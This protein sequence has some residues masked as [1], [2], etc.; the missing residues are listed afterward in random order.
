[1]NPT[2]L[3]SV[4]VQKYSTATTAT[5]KITLRNFCLRYICINMNGKKLNTSGINKWIN[6][7]L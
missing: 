7:I 3:L 5:I 4:S 2:I 6:K 1:M